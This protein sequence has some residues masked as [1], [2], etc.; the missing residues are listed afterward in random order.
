MNQ[1][2][3]FP[4]PY[5]PPSRVTARAAAERLPQAV[6]AAPANDVSLYGAL[7]F[8]SEQ[9]VERL[10]SK[11]YADLTGYDTAAAFTV[12]GD[13]LVRVI[14]VVGIT[15]ITS[16]STT[17]TLSLGTTEAVQA[18]IANSTVNNV[19]FA[20]TDVWVDSSPA[21]D[22]E[23]MASAAWVVIGGGADI[24]MTRSADDLTAGTL[25]LYCSWKPLS[26]GATVVAA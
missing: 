7:R 15:P 26:A 9:Q 1:P 21:D 20:A 18:I 11:A 23:I 6:A 14:G 16:T 4:S 12:T 8:V 13:V 2:I 5:S 10:V 24:I 3:A 22:A 25:T 17:T 19:Q